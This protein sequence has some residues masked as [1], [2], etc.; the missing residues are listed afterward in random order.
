LTNLLTFVS[1]YGIV[2]KC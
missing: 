1:V 2:T